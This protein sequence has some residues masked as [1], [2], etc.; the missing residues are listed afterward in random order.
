MVTHTCNRQ[1]LK[2]GAE[3]SL[4]L[5]GL[6][7]MC[8]KLSREK[9]TLENKTENKEDSKLTSECTCTCTYV[10]THTHTHIHTH[11]TH[12]HTHIYIYTHTH[13]HTHT[14][15]HTHTHTHTHKH[16]YH[17]PVERVRC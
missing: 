2:K 4:G 7:A 11:H 6:P 16:M 15:T 10:H 9:P 12:I 8:G 1:G 14:N 5:T 13:R 3:R 17:R